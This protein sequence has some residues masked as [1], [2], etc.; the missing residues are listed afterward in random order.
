MRGLENSRI[1]TFPPRAG[2]TH[3]FGDTA[4][5]IRDVPQSESHRHQSKGILREGEFLRIG[6]EKS[7]LLD[8]MFAFGLLARDGEH[9]RAEVCS[10]DGE[11]IA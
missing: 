6:F 2:D 11:R 1:A 3:H 8:R 5:S 4:I 7:H 10:G 9:L